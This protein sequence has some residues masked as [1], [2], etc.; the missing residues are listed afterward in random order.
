MA[1]RRICG[2]AHSLRNENQ[3]ETQTKDE[4][5]DFTLRL[6]LS[7]QVR[8]CLV[9]QALIF[10]CSGFLVEFEESSWIK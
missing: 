7:S 5:E 2:P 6:E 3:K 4:N 9:G 10:Y 1:V 8:A